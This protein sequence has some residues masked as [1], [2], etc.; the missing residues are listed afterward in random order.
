M[1]LKRMLEQVEAFLSA[2]ER[3]RRAER[4]AMQKVLK[5][6]KKKEQALRAQAEAESDEK[7]RAALQARCT[8]VHAQRKKGIDMLKA[9]RRKKVR[10]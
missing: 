1:K 5:K 10:K 2:K 9:T 3:E 8:V 6:L 7:L 4:D